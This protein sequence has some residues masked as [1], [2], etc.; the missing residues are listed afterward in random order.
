MQIKI[1]QDIMRALGQNEARLHVMC[2]GLL[3]LLVTSNSTST[4]S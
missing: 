4:S 3:E 2:P 1:Q